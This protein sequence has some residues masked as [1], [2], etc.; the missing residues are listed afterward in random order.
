ME[1]I[2]ILI[3]ICIGPLYADNSVTRIE[4]SPEL[5]VTSLQRQAGRDQAVCENLRPGS[6]KQN[7][8]VAAKS[9]QSCPTL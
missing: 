2:Y 5:R 3:Y 9:R 8:A 7:V 1:Y 6:R 4:R